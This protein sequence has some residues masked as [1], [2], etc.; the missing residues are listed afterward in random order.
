MCW[1]LAPAGNNKLTVVSTA[2][3]TRY[4][5]WRTTYGQEGDAYLYHYQLL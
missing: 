1:A 4:G 2:A 3:S 5:E